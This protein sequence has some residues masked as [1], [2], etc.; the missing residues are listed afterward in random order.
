MISSHSMFG[1]KLHRQHHH[2]QHPLVSCIRRHLRP[3]QAYLAPTSPSDQTRHTG[4][5]AQPRA[6][7]SRESWVTRATVISGQE[8]AA[9][10]TGCYPALTTLKSRSTVMS[11]PAHAIMCLKH[12]A[13]GKIQQCCPFVCIHEQITCDSCNLQPGLHAGSAQDRIVILDVFFMWNCRF[14]GHYPAG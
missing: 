8:R 3:T 1:A 5:V 7:Q 9:E 10:L 4:R 6:A 14:R 11:Y 12:I 13:Q 2:Q